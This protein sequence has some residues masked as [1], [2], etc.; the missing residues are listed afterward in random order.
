MARTAALLYDTG[1]Q[2]AAD[3][4]PVAAA[5]VPCARRCGSP[6]PRRSSGARCSPDLEL[7]GK[8]L[9][10]RRADRGAHLDREQP[11]GLVPHRPAVHPA[12]PA[13]LVRRRAS[14]LPRRP[15]RP[16]RAHPHRAAA[17]RRRRDP[18]EVVS[19][20][21]GRKVLIPAYASLV[22][23]KCPFRTDV[24]PSTEGVGLV[25]VGECE[26]GSSWK[27]ECSIGTSKCS[28]TH[29]WS[30][31]SISGAWPSW[32]QV[33]SMATCAVQHREAGGDLGHVE[34]VHLL[35]GAARGSAR[36]APPAR[37]PFGVDSSST[38]QVSFSSLIAR[39]TMRAA[40]HEGGDRIRLVG[41]S[42]V[43]SI[44][45]R[46]DDNGDRSQG[47]RSAHPGR[48]PAGSSLLRR[49][50]RTARTRRRCCRAGHD[51]E[52]H[53]LAGQDLR[54]LEQPPDR[55]DRDE[56]TRPRPGGWTAHSPRSL[57]RA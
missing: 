49:G 37:I 13:A 27:V 38:L 34:V 44:D 6:R 22:V 21:Y 55:F 47:C 43:T 57:Q 35:R 40:T 11:R 9:R 28:A 46:G 17:R 31:S 36:A 51:A 26:A 5:R 8:T 20:R 30:S 39:G 54:G 48:R 12:E 52:D 25:L 33:S 2:A 14:P 19:R 16:R 18:F 45:D 23:R 50:R 42:P 1:E 3:R 53:E 10:G 7:G 4:G 24:Q 56:H 41:S 32:K 29:F 15:A